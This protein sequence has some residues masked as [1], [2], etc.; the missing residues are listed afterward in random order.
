MARK[1]LMV[2]NPISGTG[3]A[4]KCLCEIICFF[5]ERGWEVTVHTTLGPRDAKT[6][7][8]ESAGDYEML[9]CS[10]GDGTLSEVISGLMELGSPPVVGFIPSGSANDIAVTLNLPLEPLDAAKTVLRG[11]GVPFDVGVFNGSYF[12]YVAAFGAF[13][14]VSYSTPQAM[15]N[16][17]GHLAYVLEGIKSLSKIQSYNMKIE[18]EDEVY[19]GSFLFGAVANTLS[20]GG[21]I[22]YDKSDVKINDGLFEALFIREPKGVIELGKAVQS[23]L[24]QD[25]NDE[26]VVFFKAGKLSCLSDTPVPWTLDGEEGGAHSKVDISICPRRVTIMTGL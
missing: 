19:E 21:V 26:N 14:D 12:S 25:Y 22:K 3:R 16:N 10:G 11:R 7:A 5:T 13:S 15:K 8:A 2:M 24:N 1:M 23:V 4:A 18:T 17:L 6:V 9:V 20:I